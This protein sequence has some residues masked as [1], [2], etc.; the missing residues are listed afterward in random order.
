MS[1]IIKYE[2][3]I[4]QLELVDGE[5]V[6]K[7][8]RKETYTFTLLHKGI[9]VYEE[10]AK[11]PLIK[12]LISLSKKSKDEVVEAVLNTKFLLDLA[13]A[14]Y[15]KIENGKFFNNRATCEEFR[16]MPVA[17]HINDVNFAMALVGMATDCMIDTTKKIKG[18]KSEKK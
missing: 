12:T 3:E 4:P 17:Q 15:V 1:K 14:S 9:G 7:Q 5:L 6:E 11:E 16:K 10:M 8:S 18:D 13:S 2:F